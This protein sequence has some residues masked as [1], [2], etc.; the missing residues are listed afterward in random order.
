MTLIDT[1]RPIDIL[2]FMADRIP[3]GPQAASEAQAAMDALRLQGATARTL[4]EICAML[5]YDLRSA[6]GGEFIGLY[7]SLDGALN[8]LAREIQ[9]ERLGPGQLDALKM[10]LPPA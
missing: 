6:A 2:E 1:P 4:E 7:R 3:N 10:A 5:A 8:R 9:V